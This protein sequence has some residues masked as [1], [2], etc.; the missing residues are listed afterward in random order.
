[1][2]EHVAWHTV[3]RR[4]KHK[5]IAVQETRIIRAPLTQ[6]SLAALPSEILAFVFRHLY[7]SPEAAISLAQTCQ[8][9]ASEFLA[10]R[11]DAVGHRATST[12]IC[13]LYDVPDLKHYTRCYADID[14]WWSRDS[15]LRQIYALSEQ[16][17]AIEKMWDAA[18]SDVRKHLHWKGHRSE[19]WPM[20][21]APQ[22]Q[23]LHGSRHASIT[24]R[25]QLQSSTPLY[26]HAGGLQE[27]IMKS[28]ASTLM[29][30]LRERDCCTSIR[31][32]VYRVFGENLYFLLSQNICCSDKLDEEFDLAETDTESIDSY[33]SWDDRFNPEAE[34]LP[35][36]QQLLAITGS[37]YR[38]ESGQKGEVCGDKVIDCPK[39]D[40]N[41]CEWQNW[42]KDVWM[43]EPF[44]CEMA[45]EPR[46]YYT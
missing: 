37:W 9:L 44:S 16:P 22:H 41:F 23:E 31:V 13:P 33:I 19:P 10:H 38:G 32:K 36:S 24:C 14:V 2:T 21:Y 43:F 45:S 28:A 30:R 8:S 26:V 29:K 42:D 6:S 11:S 15:T 25:I 17:G 46:W 34:R 18:F 3:G 39:L 1:M 20:W 12:G 4:G 7:N 40:K 5:A 27:H 35:C